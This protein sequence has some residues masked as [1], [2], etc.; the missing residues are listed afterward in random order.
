VTERRPKNTGSSRRGASPAEQEEYAPY[1]PFDLAL[2]TLCR[3]KPDLRRYRALVELGVEAGDPLAQYAMATWYLHG[4]AKLRVTV[5]LRRA[6]GLLTLAAKTLNR[7]MYDLA[8]C[9]LNGV[10]TRKDTRGAYRLFRRAAALGCIPALDAQAWCLENGEG[11]RRDLRA[12]RKLDAT[13]RQLT[14]ALRRVAGRTRA[15]RRPVGTR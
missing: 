8:I 2:G 12:V 10:G 14:A 5:N 1:E 15:P 6:V 13:H 9:K 4:N 3:P 7:A 11:V